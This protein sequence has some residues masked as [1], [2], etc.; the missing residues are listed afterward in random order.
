LAEST[1]KKGAFFM[2]KIY[3]VRHGESVANTR[4]IYQGQTYNTPLS[5]MG[6][7]QAEALA[8][9]FE[10]KDINKILTS[11]LMRTK[12]TAQKVANLKHLEIF[13]TLEVI[14]TNHGEWEGLEKKVISTKWP[15]IYQL[16]QKKPS[17]VK[18]PG[19]ET[20]LETRK[21]VIRWWNCIIKENT[22]LLVVTHDN[23][24][25]I[26]L[27]EVLGLNLDNIWRFQLNPAAVTIV[28]VENGNYHLLA[29]D[30]KSHLK[31]LL[32]NLGNHAL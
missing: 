30:E 6:K 27:A 1:K 13:D 32:V 21:R 17:E 10:D 2:A 22:N 7:K 23:I 14:E 8:K 5:C 29:L 9:F 25:R 15:N 31:E 26:I 19:G 12:Q 3:L 28:E 24:I 18:F 20:F 11:P 16:W 4:G